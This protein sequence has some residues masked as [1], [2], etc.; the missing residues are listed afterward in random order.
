MRL[1]IWSSTSLPS[2]SSRSRSASS[3][4]RCSSA[5]SRSARRASVAAAL[6]RGLQ[7]GGQP[8]PLL[9]RERQLEH[10]LH[11]AQALVA[12]GLLRLALD[13]ADLAADLAEHV[14]HAHQVLLGALQLALGL[15]PARLVLADAGRLLDQAAALLGLGRDDLRDAPLLDDGVALGADPRVAEEVEHVAQAHRRLVDQVLG[16]AVAVETARDLDLRVLGELGRREAVAV[17]EAEHDLREADR[18]ARFAARED[19]VL[20][21]LA[22]QAARGLLAHRPADGVDHVRLAAAVRP[23]DGGDAGLEG[24]GRLVDEALESRD[25]ERLDAQ[26]T[27]ISRDCPARVHTAGGATYTVVSGATCGGWAGCTPTRRRWQLLARS[28]PPTCGPAA[29]A[30]AAATGSSAAPYWRR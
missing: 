18:G 25:L 4:R 8:S 22:A 10:A 6:S 29:H 3:S 7:L 16:L 23:D 27:P 30:P 20:H 1:R 11:L 12:R 21:A 24:E 17:V 9:G 2:T 26:P 14:A 28:R 13:R 15:D 5:A 19:H